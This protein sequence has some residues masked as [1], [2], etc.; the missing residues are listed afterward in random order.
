MFECVYI[1]GEREKVLCIHT[2]ISPTYTL[3]NKESPQNK[4][5]SKKWSCFVKFLQS[6]FKIIISSTKPININY[7]VE[8]INVNDDCYFYWN[9]ICCII[10]N[11]IDLME[12]DRKIDWQIHEETKTEVH[13]WKRL[14]IH[15]IYKAIINCFIK[16]THEIHE[17]V[18]GVF[19]I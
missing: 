18:M 3:M 14:Y 17:N 2:Y 1:S 13:I 5:A 8:V 15:K 12:I 9:I 10:L 16:S 19:A 4:K 7:S 11:I 6:L